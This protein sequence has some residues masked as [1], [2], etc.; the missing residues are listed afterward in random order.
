MDTGS[1][2]FPRICPQSSLPSIIYLE[3][4]RSKDY[5]IQRGDLLSLDWGIKMMNFTFDV[6]RLAYVLREGETT[7]PQ[8][9]QD[10]FEQ[11]LRVRK[12]IRKHVKPGRSG[13]ETL[14]L[15]YRKVKM[16]DSNVRR[17]KMR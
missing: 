2:A 10:A 4:A 17:S 11:G 14:E 1:V 8:P 9:V 5:I 7:V 6:K 13:A 15:L 3:R 16:P 12:I